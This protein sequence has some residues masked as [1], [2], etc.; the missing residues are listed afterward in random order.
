MRC[1]RVI[2]CYG[3]VRRKNEVSVSRFL[4][5]PD[6]FTCIDTWNLAATMLGVKRTQRSSDT[7]LHVKQINLDI[8]I[9]GKANELENFYL[10]NLM[11][12]ANNKKTA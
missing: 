5:T 1:W 4:E 12:I 10:K 2:C 9:N 7:V 6:H 3:H 11:T 8:Y